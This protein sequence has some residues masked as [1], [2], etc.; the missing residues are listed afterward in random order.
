MRKYNL[1]IGSLWVVGIVLVVTGYGAG[2]WQSTFYYA[3]LEVAPASPVI[4][5][6]QELADVMKGPALMVGFAT[7]G[8]LLFLH[9]RNHVRK[10]S[11]QN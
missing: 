2:L 1:W 10:V 8:G 3:P 6:L 7:I 9:A 4:L 11:R 5:F